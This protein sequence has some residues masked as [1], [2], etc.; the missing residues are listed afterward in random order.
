MVAAWLIHRLVERP[1][2]KIMKNALD[3][4]MATLRRVSDEPAPVKH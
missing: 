2:S 3:R 4:S 1:V